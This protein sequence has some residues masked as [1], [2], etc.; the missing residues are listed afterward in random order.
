M[1]NVVANEILRDDFC[2][3]LYSEQSKHNKYGRQ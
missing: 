3:S 2:L 1:K